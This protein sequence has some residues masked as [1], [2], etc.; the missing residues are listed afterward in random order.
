MAAVGHVRGEGWENEGNVI[1]FKIYLDRTTMLD[2][3][4]RKLRF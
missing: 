3:D 4:G 1:S 2:D